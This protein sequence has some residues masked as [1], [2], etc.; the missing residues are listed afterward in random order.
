MLRS[1]SPSSRSGTSARPPRPPPQGQVPQAAAF[2][3]PSKPE[4]GRQGQPKQLVWP[5]SE[6]AAGLPNDKIDSWRTFQ[7]F[8]FFFLLGEGE[9]G[10]RGHREKGCWYLIKSP[11]G[12][13]GSP[14]GEVEGPGGCLRRIGD[15]GGGAKY[16]FGGRNVHQGL[17]EAHMWPERNDT[18]G[19][20][21]HSWRT[22]MRPKWKPFWFRLDFRAVSPYFPLGFRGPVA[23]FLLFFDSVFDFLGAGAERPRELIF[24]LF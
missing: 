16:F 14:G 7:I 3:E 19:W 9:G 4:R 21:R 12:G 8:F 15:L 5:V 11:R 2:A 6:Q 20:P 22:K 10:V 24:G 13:G 17:L 23:R 1:P 18:Q